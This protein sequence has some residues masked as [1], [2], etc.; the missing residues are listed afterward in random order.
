MMKQPILDRYS[1]ENQINLTNGQ[2]I[3]KISNLLK[4]LD[5]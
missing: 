4:R 5:H 1:S 3:N 2:N